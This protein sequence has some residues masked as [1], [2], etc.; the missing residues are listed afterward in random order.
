MH[1]GISKTVLITKG[2]QR[3]PNIGWEGKWME[4]VEEIEYLGIIISEN[5]KIDTDIKNRV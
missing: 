3:R 5:G 4:L 2:I 1:F